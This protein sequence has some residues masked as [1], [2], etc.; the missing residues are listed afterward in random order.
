MEG[1]RKA[2]EAG[3]EKTWTVGALVTVLAGIS[4][5][6]FN[7]NKPKEYLLSCPLQNFLYKIRFAAYCWCLYSKY[8]A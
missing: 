7:E 1:A 5:G 4:S 8:Q 2:A 6:Y 3:G